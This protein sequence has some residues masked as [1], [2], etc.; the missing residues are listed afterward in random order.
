MIKKLVF[1]I[2]TSLMATGAAMANPVTENQAREIASRFMA[3]KSSTPKLMAGAPAVA[4][5]PITNQA[6]YYVF[7]SAI[8]DKGFVIIAG[9][10]RLPAVL[11]YSDSGSFDADDVPPAMQ[12]WLDGYAAQVE[13]IAAGAAP[14]VRTTSRPAIAPLLPAHW[15]QGMPYNVLLPHVDG[16]NYAHAY[17]GCVATAMTQIMGYWKYPPRPTQTIPGYTSDD[18][19][20][21][22]AMPSL[23][24]MDFDWENMHPAYYVNDS[25]SDACKAVAN[26]MLYS[27]TAMKSNFGKTQ[28]SAAF[29]AM[30]DVLMTYFGYKNTAH[31]INRASFS[32]QSWENAIYDELWAGCP[33]AYT[34]SKLSAGHAFVCDGYDGEGRFHINWGWEGKSNGYFFLNLLNPDSEGIGSAAGNYSYVKLQMAVIG[35][36]PGDVGGEG[37]AALSFEQLTLLSSTTTRESSYSNFSVTLSGQFVNT[38][39]VTS[40]FQLGWGLY[41]Q[42]G[43]LVKVLCTLGPTDALG[44]RQSFSEIRRTLSFGAGITSGTYRILPIYYIYPGEEDYQPCIGADVDYIEVTINNNSCTVKGFGISGSTA[45][46]T[47]NS[48]TI[49]GT[50]NHGKPLTI[51]LTATNAG[52]TTNDIIYMFVNGS[53]TALGLASI[54]PGKRGDIVYRYTPSSAGTIS[55]SF[56][57][58]QSGTPILYSKDVTINTMPSANLDVSYRILNVTDEEN[59]V[60][61][62]DRYSIIADVTNIGSTDYN[63]DFTARLYR[64]TN[65]NTNSSSELLSLSQSLYLPAGESKSLQFNFDHDLVNGWKYLCWLSYYSNGKTVNKSTKWYTINLIN[66][67]MIPTPRYTVVTHVEPNE[68]GTVKISSG[69]TFADDRIEAGETVTVTPNPSLGWLIC[70]I[71][72]TDSVGNSVEVMEGEGAYTFV[73]PD[74]DVDVTVNFVSLPR[75]TAIVE[76]SNGGYVQLS[77]PYVVDDKIMAGETIVVIPNAN[78]GWCCSGV[79]V[80]DSIGNSIAVSKAEDGTY[81]FIVPNSDVNVTVNFETMPSV[82][83]HVEPNCG[84]DVEFTGRTFEG[85]MFKVGETVTIIPKPNIGWQCCG[86]S[87]TDSI[88]NPVEVIDSGNGTCTFV[89][90]RSDINVTVFFER[91]TGSLFELIQGASEITSDDTYVLVSRKS[92][93]VMRCWSESDTTFQ[94]QDV[95]EWLDD[96]KNVVRV[97]DDACF[98]T[99]SQIS[100]TIVAYY[101]S[102]VYKAA[103]MTTGN[104]YIGIAGNN[105]NVILNKHIGSQSRAWVR[106]GKISNNMIPFICYAIAN[107]GLSYDNGNDVFKMM[108]I[109]VSSTNP[110]YVYFYKLVEAYNLTTDFDLA[111]GNVEVTGDVVNGTVQRGETVTF[112]VTPAHGYTTAT[113][114]VIAASGE[115]V[116][117]NLDEATGTYYFIMPAANV[118]IRATFD[119]STEPDFILGDVDRNGMVDISDLTELIDY[120]LTARGDIDLLAADVNED[121]TIDIADATELIDILLSN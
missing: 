7:N 121:G 25:T 57:L 45:K 56:S 49:S 73:M 58:N 40:R 6:A 34:G 33:V 92:D 47:V 93:K 88:G 1:L 85:N 111:Q 50:C 38:T 21:Q 82:I 72:V 15:G 2:L 66:D 28:T 12:E 100:D 105:S 115:V 112:T 26:L 20:V 77:G 65:D 106:F 61:T 120:I 18:G 29:I 46:Y 83:A 3:M 114:Q 10:D 108:T 118:T 30:P 98:F 86:V 16:S 116:S 67:P 43:E 4:A 48:C 84:G 8:A 64:V 37:T 27:T 23:E 11:G 32:T 89:M 70:G 102:Q 71:I 76:P 81:A 13:A 51:K 59:R 44:F 90:L 53:F 14:E 31:Y 79:T 39:N 52:T 107:S 95:V 62:A 41:N 96:G 104:G 110:R 117:V 5:T 17:V 75:V 36:M 103:Y 99:M 35:L 60:I 109:T 9:D 113:V 19:T 91:S 74:G 97:D 68:G 119:V 80:V 55:L 54:E 78:S 22:V 63:E 101:S 24:S 42:Q 69:H 94:S 87:V